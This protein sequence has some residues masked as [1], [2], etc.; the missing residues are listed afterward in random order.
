[1]ENVFFFFCVTFFVI[2]A[3]KWRQKV[4]RPNMPRQ[5]PT[6]TEDKRRTVLDA[7]SL[8]KSA[9][10]VKDLTEGKTNGREKILSF[11]TIIR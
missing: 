10:E 2:W 3:Y 5:N 4:S 8:Q 7:L 6:K 9:Q 11:L 1:M